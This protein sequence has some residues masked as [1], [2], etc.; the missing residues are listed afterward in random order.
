MSTA[1][2]GSRSGPTEDS[3]APAGK[4]L[5]VTAH[6]DDVDFAAAGTVAAW[7]AAGTEVVYCVITDGAAGASEPGVDLATLPLRRQ[8]EQRKAAAEVGVSDVR[9]LGYPDGRLEI[10]YE[11]RRDLTR[12]IREVRPDRVLAQSPERNWERIRASHPDHLAAGEATLRAVYPDARNP[13]AHPEL[14]APGLEAHEVG[15]VWLMAS[16]R[17]DR[18]VDITSVIERKIAAL[19]CHESQVGDPAELEE[20]VR[21]WTASTAAR[22]GLGPGRHAEAFQVVD[23]R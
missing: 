1:E 13:Y 2:A 15:E 9:F 19:T 14:R 23:T 8:S 7:T 4:V 17:A 18:F 22:G 20:F 11:L 6:P 12:V 16:P 21:R 5:V 10:T 3:A